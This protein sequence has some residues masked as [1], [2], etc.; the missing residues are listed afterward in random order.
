MGACGILIAFYLVLTVLVA[1]SLF[2]E[3]SIITYI[4]GDEW[5][6]GMNPFAYSKCLMT[7]AAVMMIVRLLSRLIIMATRV[8]GSKSE[9][10]GQLLI[11]FIRYG[12]AVATVFYCMALVGFDTT[13]LI[14]SLGIFSMIVGFG[15]Q[16]LISDILAGI[17]I[18]FEGEF[19][20]G[21]IVTVDDFRGQVLEIGLR[22]TKLM[23]VT[24]NIKIFN[25]SK[26]SSVLNMTREASYA[27]CEVGIDYN[28]DIRRVE[29]ILKKELPALGKRLGKP[30]FSTPEYVGVKSLSDSSVIIQ[31]KVKCAEKDR[32]AVSYSLNKEIFILFQENNIS[33]PFPQVTVSNRD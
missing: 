30:V 5:D 31:L 22:T 32:V 14:A 27:F 18:V 25:N 3:Q 8:F 17:S 11:S 21:D 24:Q 15:A 16:S 6:K 33:I 1:K 9:T 19:R 20:V 2:G 26:I 7:I 12:S 28:E 29:A 4:L 23:D 10:M 13:S